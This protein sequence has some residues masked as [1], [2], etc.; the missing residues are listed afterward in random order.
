MNNVGVGTSIQNGQNNMKQIIIL[1]FKTLKE[2]SEAHTKS[3]DDCIKQAE[4]LGISPEKMCEECFEENKEEGLILRY[5]RQDVEDI[6][7]WSDYEGNRCLINFY[8]GQN[9]VYDL[10]AKEM[11]AKM[12]QYS[13]IIL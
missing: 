11:D 3:C 4:D 1:P 2:Q 13:N 10:T 7:G 8:S 6:K 5:D 12:K 9:I